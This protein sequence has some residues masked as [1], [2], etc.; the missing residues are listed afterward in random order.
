MTTL[1]FNQEKSLQVILY[2]AE[3]LKRKDFHKIFKIIYFADREH[4]SNYGRTIT[5]DT[6]VAMS[7]G[8]VPSKIYD[9]LKVVRGDS[10]FA[11]Q[12]KHIFSSYFEVANWMFVNPLKPADLSLLSESDIEAIDNSLNMYGNL[13][14]DEIR[15]K[16]HDYAWCNTPKD[17]AI[18]M[19]DIMLENGES[20]EY[21]NYVQSQM[22]LQDVW[23]KYGKK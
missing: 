6:Y 23:V 14:W 8:P 19:E 11:E 20:D 9:I 2:V 5:G 4:L 15:E 10:L 13:S 12:N 18:A 1:I 7:D 22:E 3:R 17:H 21:I 16:S